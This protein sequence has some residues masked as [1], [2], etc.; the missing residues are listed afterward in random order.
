MTNNESLVTGRGHFTKRPGHSAEV[1]TSR[2]SAAKPPPDAKAQESIDSVVH[3]E[4]ISKVSAAG[5]DEEVAV[6]AGD[7]GSP[8]HDSPRLS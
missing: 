8:T 2:E 7:P 4:T 5:V 6:E 3:Q 1:Q